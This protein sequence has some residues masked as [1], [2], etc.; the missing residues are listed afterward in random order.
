MRPRKDGKPPVKK[1]DKPEGRPEIWTL[2]YVLNEVTMMEKYLATKDGKSIIHLK[3]LCHWRDYSHS[4]FQHF[5]DKMNTKASNDEIKGPDLIKY[6]KFLHVCKKIKEV[7]E[8]RLAKMAIGG[9]TNAAFTIFFLCNHF[10]YKNKEYREQHN[11]GEVEHKHSGEITLKEELASLPK[12]KLKQIKSI[13]EQDDTGPTKK[14][15]KSRT[16][17]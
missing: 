9:K 13:L 17:A 14:P 12:S 5:Q 1:T 6:E 10:D 16:S 7:L 8:M 3:E 4:Q 11:S 15:S 2:D